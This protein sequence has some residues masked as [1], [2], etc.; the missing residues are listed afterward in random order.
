IRRDDPGPHAFAG[1]E[2]PVSKEVYRVPF[3]REHAILGEQGT[4]KTAKALAW[5]DYPALP[6]GGA[7]ECQDRDGLEGGH[8]WMVRP[9]PSPPAQD[10]H[11]HRSRPRGRGGHESGR[12]WLCASE[13]HRRRSVRAFEVREVPMG[14][15]QQI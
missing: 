2:R 10:G 12:P 7:G 4:A 9:R 13:S 3:H 15:A 11:R 5:K 6:Q 8:P 1:F 14:M